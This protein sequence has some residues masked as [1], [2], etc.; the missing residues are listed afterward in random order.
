MKVMK[1]HI[2]SP[3]MF[4][5]SIN[6]VGCYEEITCLT[7]VHHFLYEISVEAINDKTFWALYKFL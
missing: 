4:V 5:F 6:F 7:L 2:V 3:C 1:H